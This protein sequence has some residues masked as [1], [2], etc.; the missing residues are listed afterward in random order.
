MQYFGEEIVD[1]SCLSKC[2]NCIQRGSFFKADG[3]NDA[4][5]VVQL[6]VELGDRKC[7]CNTLKLILSGSRQKKYKRKDLMI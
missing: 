7:S 2:D 1:F 6:M 5:K 3:K 4:L